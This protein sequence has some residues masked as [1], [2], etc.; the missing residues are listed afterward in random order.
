M[1]EVLLILCFILSLWI[2]LYRLSSK[3]RLT[4]MELRLLEAKRELDK[5]KKNFTFLM[6][7]GE[8]LSLALSKAKLLRAI[9]EV[10][11]KIGGEEG[12]P[13]QAFLLLYNYTT[14]EFIYE[15][16]FNMDRTMLEQDRFQSHRGIM[17]QV[18]KGKEPLAWEDISE[19]AL[20]KRERLSF[21][22][23]ARSLFS[24]PLIVEN[25][26]LGIINLFCKRERYEFLK[27]EPIL[28]HALRNQASIALGSA[29]QCE[30]AILDRLTKAYN[31]EYFQH[32][33]MDE[34]ERCKR[35]K[36]CVSLLMIDIDHFKPINDT[37]GHQ[38]GDEVLR[39]LAGLIKR[40]VRI[41][42][43]CARYGGEEFVAVL[44]EATGED[45]LE[46]A[47]RLRKLIQEHEFTCG[48]KSLTLTV[49][50]G[51]ST[52]SWPKDKDTTKEDLIKRADDELYRAKRE[53]RNRVCFSQ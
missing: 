28:I 44:P 45:A 16:G 2:I 47:E 31:H 19:G 27:A 3:R 26:V 46:L 34:I 20:F 25:E 12:R 42:D 41:V 22:G 1:R 24:I 36:S 32:H 8:R 33:L 23:E 53:G 15:T 29:I 21:L 7:T 14:N 11:A 43:F 9:L 38:V 18:V 35:Y 51:I 49:S 13:A 52:W 4:S 48:G 37:Y 17:G 50:I 6:E 39:E 5:D 40:N 30:L 10:F